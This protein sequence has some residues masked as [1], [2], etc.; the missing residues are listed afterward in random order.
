MLAIDL[1]VDLVGVITVS[2][3]VTK[4]TSRGE[5]EVEV[6]GLLPHRHSTPCR[7]VV[8]TLQQILGYVALVSCKI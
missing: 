8:T 2:R 5:A 4:V 1:V 6:V 3:P 7:Y